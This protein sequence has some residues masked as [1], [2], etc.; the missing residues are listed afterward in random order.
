VCVLVGVDGD[1]GTRCLT[2]RRFE[3]GYGV[4]EVEG[5]ANRTVKVKSVV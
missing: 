2:D 1:S 5:G 3:C 4:V